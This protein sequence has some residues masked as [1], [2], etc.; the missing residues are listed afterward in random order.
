MAFAKVSRAS[1]HPITDFQLQYAAKHNVAH[2]FSM[3]IGLRCALL[4]SF[5]DTSLLFSNFLIVSFSHFQN[6][7]LNL[8]TYCEFKYETKLTIYFSS[9]FFSA[10]CGTAYG[11]KKEAEKQI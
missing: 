8:Q 11:S 3:K 10:F 7:I 1:V 5:F 4:F 2:G 9:I 6:K